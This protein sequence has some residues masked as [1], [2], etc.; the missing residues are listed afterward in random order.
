MSPLSAA[1]ALAVSA[2]PLTSVTIVS[3]GHLAPSASYRG[4]VRP[5]RAG[6]C[7]DIWLT[8]DA[9]AAILRTPEGVRDVKAALCV[10]GYNPTTVACQVLGWMNEQRT[11]L[12]ASLAEENQG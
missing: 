5:S 3:S 12:A 8:C 1:I 9:H 10:A 7:M 11:A 2:R 6:K 4:H